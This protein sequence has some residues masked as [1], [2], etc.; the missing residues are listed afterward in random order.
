MRNLTLPLEIYSQNKE[1]DLLEVSRKRHYEGGEVTDKFYTSYKTL[2]NYEPTEVRIEDEGSPVSPE[3]VLAFMQ[4]GQPLKV[5]FD[6]AMITINPKSQ[7][8]LSVRGTAAR[9]KFS[10]MNKENKAVQA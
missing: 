3:K 10:A 4:A 6:N 8:E 1:F 7:Y 2:I 9:I 5:S